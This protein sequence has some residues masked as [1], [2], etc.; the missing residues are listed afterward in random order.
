MGDEVARISVSRAA[1]NDVK[2]RQVVLSLDGEPLATLMYGESVSRDVAPGAHRLRAH[3]TLV[4]KTVDFEIAPGEHA[5]FRAI[6][7]PGLGTYTMLSLLGVGP[8]YL[9]LERVYE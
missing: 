4:W 2:V 9:T 8:I 5:Q 3:N 7:R 6:N 1:A